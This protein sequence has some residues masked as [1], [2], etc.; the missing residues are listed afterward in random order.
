MAL[1]F[2]TDAAGWKF[3]LNSLYKHGADQQSQH[4][5]RGPEK[6][7]RVTLRGT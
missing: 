3:L 7:R 5:G 4:E 6:G 2:L 1:V